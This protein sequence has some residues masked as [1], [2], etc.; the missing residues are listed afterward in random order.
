MKIANKKGTVSSFFT[1]WDG[2]QWSR[3][4]W[5]EIDLELVPSM[6]DPLSMNIIW[7]D[8]KEDHS[9]CAGFRPNDDWNEYVIE[10][11]P[12]YIQWYINGNMVR[13]SEGT[14]DVLFTNKTSHIMMNFWTPTF[15]GWGDNFDP[16]G[17][18]WFV[19]YD[20]VKVERYNHDTGEFYFHWQD[21]FDTFDVNRWQ[22]SNNWTFE[23]NSTTFYASN[24]YTENGNLVLKMKEQGQFQDGMLKD[25]EGQISME[26]SEKTEKI[27]ADY[28]NQLYT[29]FVRGY[30][31][32]TE[33]RNLMV[34]RLR[35]A[36]AF[37]SQMLTVLEDLDKKSAKANLKHLKE[38]RL[39][40]EL[41]GTWIAHYKNDARV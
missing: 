19:Y 5:N 40:V 17:M 30:G 41:I 3:S 25:L 29:E 38:S 27:V 2:P 18:P 36:S 20:Y 32:E 9:Y 37:D 22:K 23:S 33:A 11:A 8:Q 15:G 13:R 16:S 31:L 10:W 35:K 21:D 14:Q 7:R 12:T 4:G 28:N 24:V 1:Y 39:T 26:I 34:E 6:E